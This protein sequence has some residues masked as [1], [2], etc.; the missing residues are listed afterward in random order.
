MCATHCEYAVL[1]GVLY[2]RAGIATH[3]RYGVL[4]ALNACGSKPRPSGSVATYAF[5]MSTR[6]SRVGVADRRDARGSCRLSAETKAR[7]VPSS[8][9]VTSTTNVSDGFAYASGAKRAAA[10]ASRDSS[11]RATESS[12]A[13]AT[14]YCD[15]RVRPVRDVR[16]VRRL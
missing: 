4:K 5:A 2:P 10:T 13:R 9:I 1:R 14:S 11:P 3:E 6:A 8:S 7:R 15:S 16:R 12:S